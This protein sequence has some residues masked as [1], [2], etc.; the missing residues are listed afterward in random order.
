ME[1]GH[2][3]ELAEGAERYSL[4]VSLSPKLQDYIL[5]SA[6]AA[7]KDG[8]LGLVLGPYQ[9]PEL[10][11]EAERASAAMPRAFSRGRHPEKGH[12]FYRLDPGLVAAVRRAQADRA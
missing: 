5:R 3:G 2:D 7:L 1:P 4:A 6:D 10:M 12:V 8:P 11:E 9:A